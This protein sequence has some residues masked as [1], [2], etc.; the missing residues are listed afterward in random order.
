MYVHMINVF[1]S[2]KTLILRRTIEQNHFCGGIDR[3]RERERKRQSERDRECREA[4][5]V[6]HMINVFLNT[7]TLILPRTN[8][9]NHCCGERDRKRERERERDREI[10]KEEKR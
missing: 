4:V 3:K 8:E 6:L 7:K 1:V 9:Q 10:E 2:T 5:N